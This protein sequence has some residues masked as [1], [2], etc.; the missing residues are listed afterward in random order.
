MDKPRICEVLGVEG[1]STS[2]LKDTKANITSMVAVA[3]MGAAK[4]VMMYLRGPSTT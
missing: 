1:E 4:R 2:R 3:Q